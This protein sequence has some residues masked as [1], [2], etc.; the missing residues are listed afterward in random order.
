[1]AIVVSDSKEMTV[2]ILEK[3]DEAIALAELLDVAPPELA[4][5]LDELTNAM[6]TK[7]LGSAYR[8]N[9]SSPNYMVDDSDMPVSE[10]IIREV[11]N[12]GMAD[13]LGVKRVG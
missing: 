7:D 2:I 1:M 3:E 6:L 11:K 12:Q 9:T 5:V 4:V 13:W 10:A 8:P